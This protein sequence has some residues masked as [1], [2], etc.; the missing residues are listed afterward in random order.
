MWC[1]SAPYET[2]DPD[3]LAVW[4]EI[5]DSQLKIHPR[6]EDLDDSRCDEDRWIFDIKGYSKRARISHLHKDFFPVLADRHVPPEVLLEFAK[7]G[8][9]LPIAQLREIMDDPAKLVFWCRTHGEYRNF[10]GPGLPRESSQ[11]LS[12]LVE[13]AGYMPRE[14]PLVAEATERMVE[15]DFQQIR[16]Q[17]RFPCLKSASFLGLPDHKKVLKPGEVHLVLSQPLEDE[18]TKE[19]FCMFAGNNVLIARDPTIRGSDIQ[20]VRCICHPELAHL[21]DVVIFS[22]RGKIPLAAKL[23]G[24]DYDGDR[25]WVCAPSRAP[26]LPCLSSPAL[27][28]FKTQALNVSCWIR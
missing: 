6:E 10:D 24:G 4:I 11:R 2:S 20:K 12:L 22:T 15:T 17:L 21:K 23:Q 27:V 18:A 28:S 16:I 19:Q 13:Q 25:F 14:N 5:R 1:I 7:A 26:A 9:E 8:I 3:H